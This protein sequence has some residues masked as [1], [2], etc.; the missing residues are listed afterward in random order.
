MSYKVVLLVTMLVCFANYSPT[1]S[2]DG[3][4]DDD[5]T[6]SALTS[7]QPHSGSEDFV[8]NGRNMLEKGHQ[9][10]LWMDVQAL[11]YFKKYINDP[12]GKLSNWTTEN[13]KEVCSWW[14][15][16]TCRKHNPRV[17]P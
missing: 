12:S 3:L 11:F 8:S 5:R 9:F 16:I 1:H 2:E 14:Y 13:S 7:L 17:V 6:A 15:G 4:Y 10:P